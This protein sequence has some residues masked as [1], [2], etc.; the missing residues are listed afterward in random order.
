MFS[1]TGQMKRVLSIVL[2]GCLLLAQTILPGTAASAEPTK[3]CSKCHC[4]GDCCAA[5]S[6][7][8]S[9]PQPATPAP[10]APRPQ[11][12]VAILALSP[13][14]SLPQPQ[15]L[16]TFFASPDLSSPQPVPYY[17]RNCAWVI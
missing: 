8:I 6:T 16:N 9:A 13:L 4:G 15:P 10:S 1:S 2:G 14:R 12:S 5:P 17:D 7:P 3:G 11:L